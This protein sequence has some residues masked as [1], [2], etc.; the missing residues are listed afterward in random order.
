LVA[1]V[2]FSCK[3]A[4]IFVHNSGRALQAPVLIRVPTSRVPPTGPLLAMHC[5]GTAINHPKCI[6]SSTC[7][8]M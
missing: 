8:I 1:S 5:T 4:V 3:N 2:A 7:A 6:L